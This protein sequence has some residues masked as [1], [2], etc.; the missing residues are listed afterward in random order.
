VYSY[1]GEPSRPIRDAGRIQQG[2][3]YTLQLK[4]DADINEGGVRA[5]GDFWERGQK[6]AYTPH[7][8]LHECP[9]HRDGLEDS[10]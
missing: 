1:W 3:I 10:R 2:T 4:H 6:P 9:L 7:L 5:H 8:L